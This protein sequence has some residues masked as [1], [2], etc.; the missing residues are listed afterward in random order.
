MEQEPSLCKH[1]WK[2]SGTHWFSGR[3]GT[4]RYKCRKCKCIGLKSS[5]DIIRPIDEF[6]GD[7]D[8]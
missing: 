7:D 6:T 5:A 8:D 2:E 4:T 1:D 3:F